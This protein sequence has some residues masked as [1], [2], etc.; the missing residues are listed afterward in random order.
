MDERGRDAELIGYRAGMA[1]RCDIPHASLSAPLVLVLVLAHCS[2]QEPPIQREPDAAPIEFGPLKT[3]TGVS[4]DICS[5]M[6]IERPAETDLVLH[7]PSGGKVT[8][9]ARGACGR[10]LADVCAHRGGSIVKGE[11]VRTRELTRV[12]DGVVFSIRLEGN[13]P[14]RVLASWSTPRTAPKMSFPCEDAAPSI[15]ADPGRP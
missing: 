12:A 15:G 6:I 14:E 5:G 7:Y 3:I 10:S 9:T 2:R 1:Q 8:L 11:C 4:V 13:V